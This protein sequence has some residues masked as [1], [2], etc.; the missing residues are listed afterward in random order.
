LAFGGRRSTLLGLPPRGRLLLALLHAHNLESL[1]S[2]SVAT[3]VAA[4][5]A[6]LLLLL[7]IVAV[8]DDPY[9]WRH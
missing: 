6:I 7:L 2:V 4:G 3:V 8:A 5:S 1:L 9:G